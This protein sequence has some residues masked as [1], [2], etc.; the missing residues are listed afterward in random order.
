MRRTEF[1]RGALVGGLVAAVVMLASSAFA[2]TG[3]GAV[4]NLGRSNAVDAKSTLKGTAAKNLQITNTGTGSA[5]GIK[6]GAG[7]APIVVNSGAGKATNL[8]AD[9]VDGLDASAF[10]QRTSRGVVLSGLTADSDG[11]VSQWFNAFGGIPTI[12]H[13]AGSGIYDITF[14]GI[15]FDEGNSILMATPDTPSADATVI[16]AGYCCGG[17][18]V[19]ETKDSTNNTFDDRGFH[20]IV[21][22]ASTSG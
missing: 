1:L 12:D 21:I 8:N 4:F 19:I 10:L 13:T 9:K 5:L 20:L 2:G 16:D 7:R 17:T 18:V 6:V 22:G 3:I 11:T 14:P 15:K